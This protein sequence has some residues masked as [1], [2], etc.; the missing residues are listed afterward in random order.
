MYLVC[1]LAS[2][3]IGALDIPLTISH[4]TITFSHVLYNNNFGE[5]EK[6]TKR[7][8]GFHY[9]LNSLLAI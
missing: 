3:C 1:S 6:K 2:W 5:M 8:K 9:K 4:V 7:E